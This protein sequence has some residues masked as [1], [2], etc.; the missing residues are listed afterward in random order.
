MRLSKLFFITLVIFGFNSWSGERGD[1]SGGQGS[2]GGDLRPARSADEH[3][4]AEALTEIKPLMLSVLR[5]YETKYHHINSQVEYAALFKDHNPLTNVYEKLKTVGFVLR[6]SDPCLNKRREPVDASVVDPRLNWGQEICF[7][8]PSIA[9]KIY[10]D[11]AMLRELIGLLGHELLH[12]MGVE[13]E[14]QANNF[15]AMLSSSHRYYPSILNGFNSG[16]N[17]FNNLVQRSLEDFKERKKN[18]LLAKGFSQTTICQMNTSFSEKLSALQ[19][20]DKNYA[21][22]DIDSYWL[23]QKV[24]FS[25]IFAA[26]SCLSAPDIDAI[27]STRSRTIMAKIQNQKSITLSQLYFLFSTNEPQPALPDKIVPAPYRDHTIKLAKPGNRQEMRDLLVESSKDLDPLIAQIEDLLRE[28]N[29][30][31]IVYSDYS[32]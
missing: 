3:R 29:P 6:S 20:Y 27:V 7:T 9:Q 25:N 24:M 11:E 4:V 19:A 5:G 21:Y 10:S 13:S 15:Q 2:G 14:E 23:F 22:F 32:R 12:L 26:Y 30:P 16:S 31:K 8:I 17:E 28:N 18:M 1:R